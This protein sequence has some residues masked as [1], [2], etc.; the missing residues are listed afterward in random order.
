VEEIF[1]PAIE[2]AVHGV[3]DVRPTEIYTAELLVL[4]SS[5]F[6]NELVIE[7]LKSYKSQGIENNPRIIN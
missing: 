6:E 5:A 3:N 1:L 4:E 2:C 7:K